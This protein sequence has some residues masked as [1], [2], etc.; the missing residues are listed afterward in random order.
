MERKHVVVGKEPNIY[1]LARL[2]QICGDNIG[3][4]YEVVHTLE[5]AYKL[6]GVRPEDFAE[7]IYPERMAA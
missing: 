6:V 7:R 1:G 2:F 5:E 3:K 4:D